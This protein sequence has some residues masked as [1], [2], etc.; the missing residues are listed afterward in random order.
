MGEI[1]NNEL[2]LSFG[3][4]LFLEWRSPRF[5]TSN[6]T[7]L[8]N[9]VW[10]WLIRTRKSAYQAIKQFGGPPSARNGPVWCFARYGQSTTVLQD[11]RKLY[12]AGEHE[13]YYDPNFF[14]YNDVVVQNANGTHSIYG[15]PKAL[16]PPTDFH[17]AT[18]APEHI[19]IVGNLGYQNER[20][21]GETQILRLNLRSFEIEQIH[22]S[23]EAPGWIHQHA[24]TLSEDGRKILITGGL[25]D[26]GEKKSLWENIDEWE[27]DLTDWAWTRKT[28]KGWQRWMFIKKNRKANYLWQLREA[29]W[30]RNLDWKSD[31]EKQLQAVTLELG[32]EPN[33][34]LLPLLYHVDSTVVEIVSKTNEHG[35]YRIS[36][37]DTLVRF[38]ENHSGIHVM[39]EGRL[40]PK[41][42]ESLQTTVCRKLAQ[43]EGSDWEI[44]EA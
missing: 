26:R 16:F 21:Q 30:C 1:S 25:I 42:L 24:A 29:L 19:V 5:G 7:N 12:I 13:D 4:E 39:V 36:M 10:E 6:P 37:D 23:G 27:L 32:H 15:Y 28:N 11:G 9:P 17:S 43:I 35:I 41:R 20:K 8:S 18:S 22:G 34:D 3:R 40:S 14:I 31:Y 38:K 44:E 2:P 33:L